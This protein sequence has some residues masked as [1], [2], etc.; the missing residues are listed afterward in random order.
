[1]FRWG[2]LI[3]LDMALYLSSVYFLLPRNF[4]LPPCFD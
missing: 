1:V 3:A 4:W 2:R